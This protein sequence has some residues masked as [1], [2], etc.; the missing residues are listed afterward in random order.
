MRIDF[1]QLSRDPVEAVAA[2]LAR[3][4]VQTGSRLLIVAQNAEKRQE[5][6]RALWE[7]PGEF[8]ANG[9]AGGPH[10][11]R[12]PIL[13]SGG[14]EAPNG[15]SIVLVADG[16]WSEEASR[17]ERCLLLFDEAATND[18]RNLW[19]TLKAAENRELHIFKQ[20]ENGSWAEGA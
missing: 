9:E 4:V 15:A 13:V 12:Q 1:Y 20:R 7:V 6:S 5:I 14:F 11:A 2:M 3:K 16:I 8:L 17:F 18:A 19:K 10:D